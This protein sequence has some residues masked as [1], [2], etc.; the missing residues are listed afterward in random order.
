MMKRQG[1]AITAWGLFGD[2]GPT[3]MSMTPV[4]LTVFGIVS[5]SWV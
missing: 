2:R 3:L 1:L 4:E 5:C